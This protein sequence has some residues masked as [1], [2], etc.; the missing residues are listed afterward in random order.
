M[1]ISILVFFLSTFY[2]LSQDYFTK[3]YKPF[4]NNVESPE[5]FLEY[6]IGEQHT[7]HD[8]IVSY[9][10]RLASVSKRAAITYYGKTHE[11][12]KLTFLIVSSEENLEKLDEI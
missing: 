11:G 7:R 9:F 10:Q 6:G 4:L 2:L 3:R 12:R 5:R 1:R 8:Q